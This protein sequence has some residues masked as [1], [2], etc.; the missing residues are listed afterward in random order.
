MTKNEY[1][2]R[3]IASYI[4]RTVDPEN[5]LI[6]ISILTKPYLIEVATL[7]RVLLDLIGEF[8]GDGV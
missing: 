1:L 6:L 3:R 7:E 2:V 5:M 8:E 4:S